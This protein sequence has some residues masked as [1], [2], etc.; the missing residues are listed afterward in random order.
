MNRIHVE[1]THR[2]SF[3]SA[4]L[5]KLAERFYYIKIECTRLWN[6]LNDYTAILEDSEGG[7]EHKTQ[8]FTRAKAILIARQEKGHDKTHPEEV[9]KRADAD[10]ILQQ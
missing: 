1:T 2:D 6:E 9:T 4:E 3:A 5:E 10:A 8:L 7:V